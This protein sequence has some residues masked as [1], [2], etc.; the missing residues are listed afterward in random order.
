MENLFIA[1]PPTRTRFFLILT[2]YP[3]PFHDI[4]NAPKQT[5]WK[6]EQVKCIANENNSISGNSTNRTST[7]TPQ[8]PRIILSFF[9]SSCSSSISFC[10]CLTLN[11][12]SRCSYHGE[13][14]TNSSCSP[15]H[16]L[17]SDSVD[18]TIFLTLAQSTLPARRFFSFIFRYG[19]LCNQAIRP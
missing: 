15:S 4:L 17:Y 14:P 7:E 11:I 8:L 12:L 1:I 19:K 6:Q 13:L 2:S 9:F 5:E 3:I 16:R 10:D 18:T